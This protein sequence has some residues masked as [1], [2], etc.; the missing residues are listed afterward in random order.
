MSPPP[1]QATSCSLKLP[2]GLVKTQMGTSPLGFGRSA[3]FEGP[4]N[5][6][7]SLG[8]DGHE[9]P[10]APQCHA[11]G[12]RLLR[13]LQLQ[14]WGLGTSAVALRGRDSG[15]CF[16]SPTFPFPPNR[17]PEER[18][19]R[20]GQRVGSLEVGHRDGQAGALVLSPLRGCLLPGQ[21][22]AWWPKESCSPCLSVLPRGRLSAFC[23]LTS[24]QCRL[25]CPGCRSWLLLVPWR[26]LPLGGA[27][28]RLGTWVSVDSEEAGSRTGWALRLRP[29]LRHGSSRMTTK[30][31]LAGCCSWEPPGSG[32]AEGRGREGT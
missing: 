19:S 12:T 11:A 9:P 18:G 1:C 29:P 4:V 3:L 2:G 26:A 27:G 8:Q 15:S 7:L 31:W 25:H 13:L 30:R 5:S 20:L 14:C 22:P 24:S 32:E 21:V 6:E 23:L 10:F 17:F 28:T 16:S